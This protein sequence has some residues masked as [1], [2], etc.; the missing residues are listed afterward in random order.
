MGGEFVAA[1]G[2]E[3][4]DQ[5]TAAFDE[6]FFY[7]VGGDCFFRVLAR[8]GKILVASVDLAAHGRSGLGTD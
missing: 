1:F 4:L 2:D 6:E 3:I 7:F 5:R 8:G